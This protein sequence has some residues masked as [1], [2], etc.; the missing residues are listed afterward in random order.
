MGCEPRGGK[1]CHVYLDP[2]PR[3][4]TQQSGFTSLGFLWLTKSSLKILLM[5][6]ETLQ[7]YWVASTFY[8]D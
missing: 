1:L 4:G 5:G 7:A 6:R 3:L 8:A 2:L